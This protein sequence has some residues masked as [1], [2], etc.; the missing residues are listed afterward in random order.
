MKVLRE[1]H[2]Y[3]LAGFE[4]V[5][6]TQEIQFIE[7][8]PVEG[9]T[10]LETLNDGTTN[11]EVIEMLL[12]RMHYLQ[13]KFPCKENISAINHLEGALKALNSRNADRKKRNVE[14]KQIK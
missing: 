4:D 12:H 14:G 8:V 2:K 1:G 7:K 11:E 5:N 6:N 3:A 10:T 9:T 13:N